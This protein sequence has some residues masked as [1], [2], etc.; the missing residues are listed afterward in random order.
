M[1]KIIIFYLFFSTLLI[2][3]YGLKQKTPFIYNDHSETKAAILDFFSNSFTKKTHLNLAFKLLF[4]FGNILHYK[5]TQDLERLLLWPLISFNGLHLYLLLKSL[6]LNRFQKFRISYFKILNWS[7]KYFSK[8]YQIYGLILIGSLVAF[9]FNSLESFVLSLFFI[10]TFKLT[11]YKSRLDSILIYSLTYLV[12]A[13]YFE[14]NFSFFACAFSYFLILIYK[15]TYKLMLILLVSLIYIRHFIFD[16]VIKFFI[17][18][19]HQASAI[20]YIDQTSATVLL[21]LVLFICYW[22]KR[23]W[24]I[25]F[26]IIFHANWVYTPPIYLSK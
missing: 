23:P 18:F 10:M 15:K 2:I 4:G 1:K 11:E 8:N 6:K 24:P 22:K 5:V 17:E 26:F 21:F 19:I 16:F 13:I 14:R 20:T 3:S 12:L 7:E 25:L 9:Y